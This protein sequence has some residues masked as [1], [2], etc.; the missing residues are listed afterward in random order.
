MNT[1]FEKLWKLVSNQFHTVDY[2]VHGPDHWRRVERNALLLAT[3]T[4]ANIEVVRLFAVFHDSRRLNDD[5][6]PDH[7]KRGAEFAATLRGNAL[8]CPI[9]FSNSS[10]KPVSGTPIKIT[11]PILQ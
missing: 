9:H 3:R 5:W 4:G 10:Q 6:D 11:T 7:G 1:D 2:S 8:I